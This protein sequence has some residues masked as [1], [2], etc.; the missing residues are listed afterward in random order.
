MALIFI[1]SIL[2]DMRCQICIYAEDTSIYFY[3]NS[4]NDISDRTDIVK[5]V[6]SKRISYI[7]VIIGNSF[8]LTFSWAVLTLA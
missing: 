1:N 3:I 4:K 7:Y 5:L 6:G 8:G 2:D